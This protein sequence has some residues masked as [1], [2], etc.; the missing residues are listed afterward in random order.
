[1][2]LFIREKEVDELI[3]MDEAI[4][5][6][7]EA[8]RYQ[9][10]GLA[11]IIPRNRIYSQNF[12]FN[13]MSASI[14]PWNVVGLKT[15]LSTKKVTSF[16]IIIFDTNFTEPIAIIEADR[17]GQIRTGAAS[18]LAT[19]YLAKKNARIISVIGAGRQARTQVI[20]I[21]EALKAEKI[22][23]YS[24]TYSKAVIMAEELKKYNYNVE[25]VENYMKACD[26]D[27]IS[28]ATNSKEPFLRPEWIKTGTHINLIGSNVISKAEAF[29]ET[30]GM[31]SLVVTDL[32]EQA[33]IESGDLIRA[34]EKGF[35]KWDSV[36]ELWEVVLGNA[37]RVNDDEI[38]IFKSH[39]IALWDVAIAKKV[40]EKA[41]KRNIGFEIELKGQWNIG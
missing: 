28:T 5:I 7:E 34:V 33:M 13:V 18:G 32:K 35:L 23:V 27:V 14:E 8:T 31:A 41:I 3:T 6:I 29:P 10:Q 15:Y 20:G 17:L 9:G 1:M 19:K 38:T 40:Y 12:V 37:K 26:A 39:G 2:T 22:L 16:V 4:K 11:K 21:A 24:R 36:R 25:V 30:I